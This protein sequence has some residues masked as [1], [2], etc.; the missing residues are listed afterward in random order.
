MNIKSLNPRS[1]FRVRVGTINSVFR[2]RVGTIN[3]TS[4]LPGALSPEPPRFRA[5]TGQRGEASGA[6]TS[7][8]KPFQ[9]RLGFPP[10]LLLLLLLLL[11]VVVVVAAAVVVVQL[12]L[13]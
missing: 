13:V 11:V 8:M 5:A 6:S 1:V 12:A 2:V 4:H 3:D 10:M 9:V 7:M